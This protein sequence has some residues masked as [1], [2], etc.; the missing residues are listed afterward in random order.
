[1]LTCPTIEQRSWVLFVYILQDRRRTQLVSPGSR[2]K[3]IRL[4]QSNR[5]CRPID[6]TSIK[7]SQPTNTMDRG[8]S[9]D[10]PS[11]S[12]VLAGIEV[13]R[14]SSGFFSKFD[15]SRCEWR[16]LNKRKTTHALALKNEAGLAWLRFISTTEYTSLT[17]GKFVSWTMRI[18][19]S[20]ENYTELK[21]R[22]IQYGILL[23]VWDPNQLSDKID[24][25]TK[26]E[27][28]HARIQTLFESDNTSLIIR[29][30]DNG[31]FPFIYN[32]DEIRIG[33]KEFPEPGWTVYDF[34]CN[35]IVAVEAQIHSR[36]FKMG[37]QPYGA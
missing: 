11:I 32:G 35:K 2:K 3:G 28:V 25:S 31:Y 16:P 5:E 34:F 20:K 27:Y 7:E 26:R 13:V 10:R 33:K 9:T 15:W 30:L 19:L 23:S 6:A 18:R 37:S 24:I 21:R 17:I 4:L 36:N 29:T 12:L 22:L 14:K 8:N 1:M